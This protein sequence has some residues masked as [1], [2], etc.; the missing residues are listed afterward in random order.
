MSSE[1]SARNVAQMRYVYLRCFGSD[2]SSARSLRPRE[3]DA[4]KIEGDGADLIDRGGIS[5]AQVAGSLDGGF[6]G[7]AIQDVEA[8]QLF[9]GLGKRTIEDEACA[10][11]AQGAGLLGRAQTRR[12]SEAPLLIDPVMDLMQTGH[13][14]RILLRCPGRDFCFHMI[15]LDGVKHRYLFSLRDRLILKTFCR[16]KSR[17]SHVSENLHH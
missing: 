12:R 16:S 13:D 8:Q 3:R 6:F 4:G 5:A 2:G 17:Q 1:A 15:G 11:T 10:R 7:G 9:L 14:R